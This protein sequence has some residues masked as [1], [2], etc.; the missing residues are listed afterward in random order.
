LRSSLLAIDFLWGFHVL[1][2]PHATGSMQGVEE[3]HRCHTVTHKEKQTKPKK[4]P[5]TTAILWC[6]KNCH[7]HT[8]SQLNQSFQKLPNRL[9]QP[10]TTTLQCPAKT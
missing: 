2:H 9:V 3:K 5:P 7:T 4:Q 6:R 8:K 10:A 1:P